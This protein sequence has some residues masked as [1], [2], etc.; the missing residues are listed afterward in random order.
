MTSRTRPNG[1]M[2]MDPLIHDVAHHRFA[3]ALG[4]ENSAF[5]SYYE[6]DHHL[7]LDHTEVPVAFGGRGIGA[8]LAQAV[9]DHLRTTGQRVE[10]ECSFLKRF[11]TLHPEYAAIVVPAPGS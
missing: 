4:A 6:K 5:I 2:P 10:L 8:R 11:V 7:V 9:F 3:I 1:T